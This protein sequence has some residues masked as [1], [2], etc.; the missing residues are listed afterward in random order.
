MTTLAW[1]GITLAADSQQTAGDL[2]WNGSVKKILKNVGPFDALAGCGNLGEM[3]AYLP[4]IY[5][6]SSLPL[7]RQVQLPPKDVE[8]LGIINGVCYSIGDGGICK[9]PS[10]CAAG[11]GE[12]LAIAAMDFGKTAVEAVKYA[13]TRDI[14]TNNRVTYYRK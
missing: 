6:S 2:V 14:H 11:S 1:D 10:K 9:A 12:H 13:A 4:T 3:E 7:L 8:F 5:R